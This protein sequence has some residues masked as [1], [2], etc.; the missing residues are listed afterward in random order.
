[1]PLTAGGP[2]TEWAL[3]GVVY[4]D[5]REFLARYMEGFG[6]VPAGCRSIADEI[7]RRYPAI[8]S[9]DH[10]TVP[11]LLRIINDGVGDPHDVDELGIALDL[12]DYMARRR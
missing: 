2:F 5:G 8:R 3:D 4:R 6:W 7:Y 11:E 12:L 10:V 9:D 1:M